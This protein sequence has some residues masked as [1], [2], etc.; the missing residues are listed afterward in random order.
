MFFPTCRHRLLGKGFA[1]STSGVRVR[2]YAQCIDISACRLLYR[3]IN[4]ISLVD[5]TAAVPDV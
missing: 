2:V 3:P 4:T 5:L 1:V